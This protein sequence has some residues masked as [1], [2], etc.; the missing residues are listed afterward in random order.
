MNFSNVIGTIY[1]SI[2]Q[3]LQLAIQMKNIDCPYLFQVIS[4]EKFEEFN[5]FKKSEQLDESTIEDD[6]EATL[7]RVQLFL[8]D[9]EKFVAMDYYWG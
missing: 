9:T 4:Q 2:E 5:E 6:V 3:I 1:E 8:S 7:E